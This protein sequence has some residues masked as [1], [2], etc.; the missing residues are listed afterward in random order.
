MEIKSKYNYSNETKGSYLNNSNNCWEKVKGYIT[1]GG[2]SVWRCPICKE[3]IHVMGIEHLSN[4]HNH[5]SNCGAMLL[6]P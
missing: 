4:H 1:P 5:C 6:Y 2:D 3:D